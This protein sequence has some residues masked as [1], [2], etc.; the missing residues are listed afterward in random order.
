LNIRVNIVKFFHVTILV[1][2][3]SSQDK[4]RWVVDAVGWGLIIRVLEYTHNSRA[5]EASQKKLPVD[6]RGEDSCKLAVILKRIKEPAG[7]AK[8]R[9]RVVL[10][11]LNILT[12]L[13][14]RLL[15]SLVPRRCVATPITA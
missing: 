10:V 7:Y 13:R 5:E 6:I 2:R 15:V 3:S 14:Y 11:L 8:G 12:I 1:W 9:Q 4:S